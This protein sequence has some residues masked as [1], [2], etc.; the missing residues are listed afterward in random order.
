[1]AEGP[2]KQM[3]GLNLLKREEGYRKKEVPR[4]DGAFTEMNLLLRRV[5]IVKGKSKMRGN[6]GDQGGGKERKIQFQHEVNYQLHQG[7]NEKAEKAC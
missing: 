4:E 7:K 2:K 5:G 3:Q 1:M 6:S